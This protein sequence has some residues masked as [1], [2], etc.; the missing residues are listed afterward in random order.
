MEHEPEDERH[1]RERSNDIGF[2]RI[3]HD[4]GED[5][6]AES[7]AE[8]GQES[9]PDGRPREGEAR[10]Y[11][12]R[13]AENARRNRN[14]VADYGNEASEKGVETVVLIEKRLRFFV[15]LTVDEEILSV[16]LDERLSYVFAEEIVRR[17]S[18]KASEAA[19]EHNEKGVELPCRGQVSGRNHDEFRRNGKQA[20]FERHEKENPGVRKSAEGVDDGFYEVREQGVFGLGNADYNFAK[21]AIAIGMVK[22]FEARTSFFMRNLVATRAKSEPTANPTMTSPG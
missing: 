10:E 1:Y 8:P 4:R 12:V 21:A 16:F 22:S 11:R 7:E 13:H 9:A 6:F 5:A 15:F 14:K 17:G 20:R 19:G 18:K 2:V 3:F